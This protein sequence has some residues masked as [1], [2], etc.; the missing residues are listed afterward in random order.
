MT[1][2]RTAATLIVLLAAAA[3][4]G[5][6]AATRPVPLTGQPPSWLVGSPTTPSTPPASRPAAASSGRTGLPSTGL[7]LVG[8]ATAAVALL[9]LGLAVRVAL[10]RGA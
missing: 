3:P 6:A 10:P 7:G 8:E 5:A 4:S 9:G 1:G 2:N